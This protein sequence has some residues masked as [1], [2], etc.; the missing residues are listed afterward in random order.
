MTATFRFPP[1]AVLVFLAVATGIPAQDEGP[2]LA[3]N[4]QNKTLRHQNE[5]NGVFMK[6]GFVYVGGGAPDG[7][8]SKVKI[9]DG[10]VVWSS[11]TNQSYQPS[12][13]VSNGRVVVFGKYYEHSIVG[14]DDEDGE[15][16]WTVPTG[17]QNMSAACFAGDLAFIGSY[18][19]HLYAIDWAAGKT[20]WKAVLG[21]LIWSTPCAYEKLVLVGCYDGFLYAI[22]QSGGKIAWK[23]DCGGKIGSNP[24]VANGLA[25]IGVDDQKYGENYDSSKQQKR[26]LVIDLKTKQVVSRFPADDQWSSKVLVSDGDV[27]FFDAK[28]LYSYNSKQAKLS[29][30]VEVDGGSLAYP[31]VTKSAVIMAMNYL[32]HHGE[33]R[34]RTM[35]FDRASGKLLDTSESGGIGM[36]KPHYVQDGDQVVTAEW[37]LSGHTIK[38]TQ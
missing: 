36:R 14:L 12:Y 28:S 20:R 23:V 11:D 18:D 35:R 17:G 33:H 19:K 37:M 9:S 1:L 16:L 24:V 38:A 8:V 4:W 7:K 31:L 30:K 26:L 25:F 5:A 6:D 15:T 34:S 10:K 29:W 3:L 27:Y 32:G 22:E 2:G 13:P 21:N